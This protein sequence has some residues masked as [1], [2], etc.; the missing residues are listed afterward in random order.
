MS[1]RRTVDSFFLSFFFLFVL[2]VAVL[3]AQCIVCAELA[4]EQVL[5]LVVTGLFV[6]TVFRIFHSR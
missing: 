1:L 2:A 6:L 5:L 4:D 3:V